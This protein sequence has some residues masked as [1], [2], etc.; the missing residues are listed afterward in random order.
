MP[1]EVPFN[2]QWSAIQTRSKWVTQQVFQWTELTRICSGWLILEMDYRLK[3]E[4]QLFN[5]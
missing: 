1:S 2:L 5:L 4:E 3:F